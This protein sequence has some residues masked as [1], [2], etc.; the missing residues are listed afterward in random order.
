VPEPELTMDVSQLTSRGKRAPLTAPGTSR[1]R[2]APRLVSVIMPVRNG[3]GTLSQ[4]LEAL[5]RQT[6]DRPWELIVADNGS[7]DGTRR[8]AEGFVGRLP[9]LRVVDASRCPGIGVARNVGAGAASG[10]F[11]AYCDADDEATEGW[12]GGLVTSAADYDMV[13]GRLDHASL[14]D[15]TAQAWRDRLAADRLPE[16][17][18]FLPYA[19]GS[20][21]GMW[22]DVLRAVGGW[23]EEYDSCGD[24]VE[25]SWRVQLAGYSLGFAPN[26]VMRYRHRHDL[27][28]MMKQAYAYGLSDARLYAQFR[29]AGVPRQSLSRDLIGWA[30]LV[31]QLPDVLRSQARRGRWLRQLALRWGRLREGAGHRG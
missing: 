20:N 13:G 16:K 4:Q 1:R 2:E 14:N 30:S 10:Q 29:S 24:D 6:Y 8:I 17:L 23:S 11:L 26:A 9:A 21:V 31:V 18:G 15:R 12:L 27:R 25:M 22:A 3:S 7:V 5:R 28:G 19:V